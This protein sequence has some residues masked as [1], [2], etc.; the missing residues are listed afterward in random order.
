M[1]KI[2]Q[3]SPFAKRCFG[4]VSHKV[5][6]NFDAVCIFYCEMFWHKCALGITP[7]AGS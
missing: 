2:P 3:P 7:F 4:S 1:H 5:A 6:M